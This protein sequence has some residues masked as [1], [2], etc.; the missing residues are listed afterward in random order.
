MT[1]TMPVQGWPMV[2]P[3]VRADDPDPVDQRLLHIGAEVD[4]LED[5]LTG[6]LV[7]EWRL[8]TYNPTC[9]CSPAGTGKAHRVAPYRS[10][11][12]T[13]RGVLAGTLALTPAT[14]E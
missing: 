4:G 6:W 8:A 9:S 7:P 10:V 1:A 3:A 14:G 2:S 12:K 11:S 13:A 5:P